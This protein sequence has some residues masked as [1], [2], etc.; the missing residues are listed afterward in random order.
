LLTRE[1]FALYRDALRE[2]GI[3]AVHVS[4]RYLD[5]TPVVRGLA[6]EQGKKV[7]TIEADDDDQRALDRSTWMLVTGNADFIDAVKVYADPD[8]QDRTI[9]W[10][11]AFSSL[12]QV[13]KRR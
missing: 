7:L 13:L 11:D 8:S 1:A 2:D 10:T 5:L 3:L 12:L 4:N 9:V 6:A